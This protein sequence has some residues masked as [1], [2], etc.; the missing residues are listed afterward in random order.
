MLPVTTMQRYRD[1]SRST[2]NLEFDGRIGRVRRFALLTC[3]DGHCGG[4]CWYRIAE[5]G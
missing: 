1:F 5:R 2:M 4:N 3:S